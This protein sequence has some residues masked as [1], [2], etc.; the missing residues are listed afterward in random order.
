MRDDTKVSY[1][2]IDQNTL[3]D[4]TSLGEGENIMLFTPAIPTLQGSPEDVDPFESFGIALSQYHKGVKHIPY[5]PS[6][7]FTD[8]HDAFLPHASAVILV[9]AEPDPRTSS[10]KESLKTQAKYLKNFTPK[11]IAKDVPA[12]LI[13]ISESTS[14]TKIKGGGFGVVISATDY[15]KEQLQRLAAAI[16]EHEGM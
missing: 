4:F 9:L 11:I 14:K 15:G 16:F 5:L 1:I 8:Y 12:I 13:I 2:R 6:Q 7:G 10:S 3:H